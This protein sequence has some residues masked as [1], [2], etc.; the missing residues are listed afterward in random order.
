MKNNGFTLIEL[1]AVIVILSIISLIATPIILNIIKDSK[2]SSDEQTVEL[3]LDTVKTAIV[4]KQLSNPNFNPDV[5]EIENNGN[6]M[7]FYKEKSLGIIEVDIKG[8]IPSSG[9]ITLDNNKY[10]YKNIMYNG[11]KYYTFSILISDEDQNNVISVGDKY[12]IK[13]SDTESFIFYVLSIKE[14]K[15]NLIMNNN[16][17]EDGSIVTNDNKCVYA[18]SSKEDYNDENFPNWGWNKKG[19]ITAMQKLY[20]A[21]KNWSKVPNMIMNYDDEYNKNEE[22]LGYIGIYTDKETLVTTIKAKNADST[23]IKM[24]ERKPLKA[25]LPM[26]K[27]MT[28]RKCGWS[29]WQASSSNGTCD[30]FL[31]EG[32]TYYDTTEYHSI[33]KYAINK[34]NGLEQI[35]GYWTLSSG[36][37][38]WQN[39]NRAFYIYYVGYVGDTNTN[40]LSFGIRPVITVPIEYLV[41]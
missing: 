25:R 26:V 7:C 40:S 36:K 3:Y 24:E 12:E 5:C 20:D 34:N 15:V 27:E 35:N 13:V 18:W 33:D 1:L 41:N 29:Y 9:I 32:L 37:R 10:D 31:V 6:L 23:I 11:K 4:R 30:S 21:T 38:D 39:N 22:N 19:P 28:S 2:N 16:I 17:C 14:N 8:E